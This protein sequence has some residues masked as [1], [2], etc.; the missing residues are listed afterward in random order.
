MNNL[1][2][3]CEQ[4]GLY[5]DCLG[6]VPAVGPLDSQLVIIG[7]SP[8]QEEN[9]K[10]E[11]FI[12][13]TGKLLT[14]MMKEAGLVRSHYRI[15]NA[16][17]CFPNKQKLTVKHAEYCKPILLKELSLLKNLKCIVAFGNFASS[18]LLGR[19]GIL[20]LNGYIFNWNEVPVLTMLHPSHT[21]RNLAE[22]EIQIKHLKKVNE[23]L[24]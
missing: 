5:K 21:L 20:E 7:E 6:P 8:G 15:T 24:K 16:I 19:S 4:C 9:Q 2:K 13:D 1:N 3:Q 11:P 23:V 18:S 22:L 12:G 14:Y 10:G 17:K